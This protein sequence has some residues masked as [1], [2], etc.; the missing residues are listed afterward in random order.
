MRDVMFDL[1]TLA[2]S[3]NAVILSIGAVRFDPDTGEMAEKFYANIDPSSQRWRE[4]DPDTV[5]WWDKQGQAAQDKLTEAPVFPLREALIMFKE[6]LRSSDLLWSNGP[7]FDEM[8]IRSAFEQ[9]DGKFPVGYYNSRCCRTEFALGKRLG[10]P[11]VSPEL[12]HDALS[13]SIAQAMTV[14]NIRNELKRLR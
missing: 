2:T 7:T 11:K 3:T 14:I 8:I 6:F 5:A 9:L 13:D 4:V 1:E 10:I 12:K